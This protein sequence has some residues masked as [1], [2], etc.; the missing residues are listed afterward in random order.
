[1]QHSL[2]M[3]NMLNMVGIIKFGNPSLI[4]LNY[5][6]NSLRKTSKFTW[7]EVDS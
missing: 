5:F 2:N 3:L 6:R 7:N 4:H 1:M